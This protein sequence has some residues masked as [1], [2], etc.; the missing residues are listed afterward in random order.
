MTLDE[1]MKEFLLNKK[2]EGVSQKTI[3]SYKNSI[4]LMVRTIGENVCVEDI[5]KSMVFEYILQLQ[6]RSLSK[7]TVS[8]YVRD[9]RIFLRWIDNE[10][11]LNF[12]PTKIK[13]PKSPKKNV[14]IYNDDEIQVI[15][16]NI[17]TSISWITARN[18]AIVAIML[19]SGLRQNE[20]CT[21]TCD[22]VDSSRMVMKVTGKGAKDRVVP[23]GKFAYAFI[24]YYRSQCPYK[25]TTYVFVDK[26]GNPMTCN[27]VKLFVNRLQR[28]LPF[29]LSSHR[30][31][32][33]F[34]TNF[35]I[36]HVK[37]TGRSDVYD[38][39]ILMGHESIETTKKYEHFAHEIIAAENNISHLDLCLGNLGKSTADMMR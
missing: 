1:A 33:N 34:A 9:V 16:D 35:C 25:D 5:S 11:G 20:I 28:K 15:F 19:D 36:D 4:V 17:H 8:S 21:L 32:H 27:A 13:V 39:S 10:Y 2:V 14:H 31:R 18:K 37:K 23:L 22:N 29:Q 12:D 26:Y 38:L 24:E 3:A 7:A 6:E 30:L